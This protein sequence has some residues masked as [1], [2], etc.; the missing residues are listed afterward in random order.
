VNSHGHDSHLLYNRPIPYPD[1]LS[2]LK[3]IALPSKPSMIT[4][5]KYGFRLSGHYSVEPLAPSFHTDVS[6]SQ[7]LMF[8]A[9]VRDA[10]ANQ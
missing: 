2:R 7:G 3:L 10:K 4:T 6:S 8:Y 1:L 5:T 9:A